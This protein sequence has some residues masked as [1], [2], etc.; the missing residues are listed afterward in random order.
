MKIKKGGKWKTIFQ[1]KYSYFK[2]QMMLF[3]LS[4]APANFQC[5][6]N[7]ILTEK[8]DIFIIIYLNDILIYNKNLDQSRIEVIQWVLDHL[9]KNGLFVNL[10]KCRFHK[11]KVQF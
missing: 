8:L 3:G 6:I 4:N 1:T 5:Y 10:K 7:K 11:N 2:Y 9:K